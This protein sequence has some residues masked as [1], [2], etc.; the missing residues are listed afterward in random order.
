M[1]RPSRVLRL[2]VGADCS[3]PATQLATAGLAVGT[4]RTIRRNPN[5][6][7]GSSRFLRRPRHG[8][9]LWARG[10]VRR[11]DREARTDRASPPVFAPIATRWLGGS[12]D[13]REA[14][15]RLI[16]FGA[17][18]ERDADPVVVDCEGEAVEAATPGHAAAFT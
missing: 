5:G 12:I 2:P 18:I 8:R 16:V 3:A 9:L 13:Q 4:A 15:A 7:A 17:R 14:P 10:E 1:V 11:H 6:G